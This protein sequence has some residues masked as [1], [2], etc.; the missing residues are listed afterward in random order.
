MRR[1]R[2]IS[3]KPEQ[4]CQFWGNDHIIHILRLHQGFLVGKKP[5]FTYFRSQVYRDRDASWRFCEACTLS[6]MIWKKSSNFILVMG[7]F[8]HYKESDIGCENVYVMSLSWGK[9][10]DSLLVTYIT[11]DKRILLVFNVLSWH[12]LFL[13][14]LSRKREAVALG[15]NLCDICW[16]YVQCKCTKEKLTF[17]R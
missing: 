6:M 7:W 3:S 13:C 17:N 8:P 16:L 5:H 12:D 11:S 10:V 15:P 4:L 9:L 2:S 14:Q 1:R